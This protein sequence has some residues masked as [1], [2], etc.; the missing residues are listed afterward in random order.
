MKTIVVTGGGGFIGS[1][2][3]AG[4]LARGTH[5]V[6]VCDRFGQDDKWLNLSKHAVAEILLPELL[7]DWLNVHHDDVE[8][9]FHIGATSSTLEKNIDLVLV[10]NFSFSLRVWRWCVKHQKRLVYASSG[11]TYGDS[12]Q[13]F[14]DDLSLE[15]LRKLKPLSGYGWSK[16]LFDSHVAGEVHHKRPVPPQWV[17]LKFFNAYGPNEYHKGDQQSVITKMALHAVQGGAVRL[18]RSMRPDYKDGGQ[19]RD[20]IY[21]KDCTK[22]MLWLID[23]PAVSGLFNLGT[24]QART[25]EDMAHAI[26]AAINKKP[27]IHYI[28]MPENL[29]DRY[30]YFTEARMQRLLDAGYK[31]PFTPLEDGVR[32]YVRHYLQQKDH[33]L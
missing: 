9:I 20:V 5:R 16:H 4:L 7:F 30:Q 33:Y 28:D 21:V 25:F 8:M 31:E 11:S 10:N 17:G 23:S 6:I 29:A 14:D 18:F 13:G 32:D 24:G 22:V 19:K 15:Y 26:F 2:L 3:V 27:S 1:N 12:T